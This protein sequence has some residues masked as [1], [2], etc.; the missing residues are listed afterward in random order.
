MKILKVKI[1]R[2]QGV[3]GTVYTYPV[4]YDP[5]KIQVLCYETT[6]MDNYDGVVDRGNDY[7]YCVG[8]VQDADAAEF[9]V[10]ADIEE[11]DYSTATTDCATW[12]K[13]VEKI[14]DQTKVLSILSK[15][16]N[17][18]ALTAEEE[19]AIDPNDTTTGIN[20]SKSFQEMLDESLA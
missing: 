9:L 15:V 13:Q 2:N 20:N 8:V 17:S 4:E 11:L 18:E 16:H 10:S 3:N 19:A 1:G 5:S 12:V 7:E 14:T 6:N